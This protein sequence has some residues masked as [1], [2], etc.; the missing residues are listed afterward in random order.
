MTV[1][2]MWLL[3]ATTRND[4][5]FNPVSKESGEWYS[6]NVTAATPAILLEVSLQSIGQ[7]PIQQNN[8]LQLLRL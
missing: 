8:H 3:H 5:D 6:A 1:H 4:T 2:L 7:E